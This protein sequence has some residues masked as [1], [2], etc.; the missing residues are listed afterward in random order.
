MDRICSSTVAGATKYAMKPPSGPASFQPGPPS[1]RKPP[2]SFT[3]GP[4]SALGLNLGQL[5]A[6]FLSSALPAGLW[7]SSSP[8]LPAQSHSQPSG[9]SGRRRRSSLL[10]TRSF[11][12]LLLLVLIGYGGMPAAGAFPLTIACLQLCC[13]GSLLQANSCIVTSSSMQLRNDLLRRA[14]QVE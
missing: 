3:F 9:R 8:T 2:R 12:L 1:Y 11:R 5:K 14:L 4:A 13:I 7:Q 6:E 10:W